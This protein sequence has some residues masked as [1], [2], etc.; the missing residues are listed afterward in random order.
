MNTIEYHALERTSPK[1]GPFISRCIRCGMTGLPMSA[2]CEECPNT[3]EMTA[4][5]ALIESVALKRIIEEVRVDKEIGRTAYNRT[6]HRHN[7][8]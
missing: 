4:D 1:G 3:R 7:R 6:Y 5:E 2:I 8:S